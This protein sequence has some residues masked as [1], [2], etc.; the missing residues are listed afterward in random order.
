MTILWHSSFENGPKEVFYKR[1]NESE[2]RIAKGDFE[3]IDHSNVKV[4]HV[5]LKNLSPD[6]FYQFHFDNEKIQSFR[7]MPNALT[8]PLNIII[9]G[10]AYFSRKLNSKMNLQAASYDPDFVILSGDIAYTEGIRRAFKSR[11][12]KINRWQ[13]FFQMWSEEMITKEGR[14][15]PIVPV[16]GN[17]DVREGFD[18]PFKKGVLF[19]QFFVFNEPGV[20]FRSMNIGKDLIFYL[21]DSGHSFPVAGRQT[22]WLE[23]EFQKG[24]GAKWHIPVYH[25]PAYPSETNHTHRGSVDIRKHWIPLFENYGVRLSM[26]H[27]CHTFKRTFPIKKGMVDQEGIFYLGDGA[28]GVFPNKPV[29]RWYLAKALQ[30]NNFWQLIIDSQEINCKAWD[31][32]G[33][34]IDKLKLE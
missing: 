19:Y 22:E 21:L 4:Y 11:A 30:I 23:K 32:E 27:D 17:H 13:E 5:E 26:E 16:V 25:I 20:P 15:I 34:L 31:N 18:N 10:D 3:L 7:T 29:R 12:W 8:R 1:I 2:W 24:Q 33:N 6:S 14:L 9:G 28:W